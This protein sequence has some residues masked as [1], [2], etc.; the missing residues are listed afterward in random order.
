MAKKGIDV[1]KHQGTIDWA[2]L[3]NKIDF[4]MLRAGYGKLETQID[5]RFKNN[6]NGAKKNNIPVGVYWY[7]YA[8]SEAEA[9]K[10]AEACLK[11]IKGKQFEYPI[12]FDIEEAS[13]LILGKSKVTKIVKA[14]CEKVEKAGYWVGIYSSKSALEDYIEEETRKRYSVWVAHVNVKKTTYSGAY[15]MWQ[16]SW[17]GSFDGIKGDV[18][19][20][21]CYT[22]F[23]TQIKKKGL[24][25][26]EKAT[27]TVSAT[28]KK[29][30]TATTKTATATA[31]K[32]TAGAKITLKDA[33][34]YVSATVANPSATKSGVYYVYDTTVKNNRIRV[35]T[36]AK[37]AGKQPPS[38]YVTGWVKLNEITT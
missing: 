13:T 3:K 20:D 2:K 12:F 33:G 36:T 7:S 15:A 22:D 17:S 9:V 37:N 27:G 10:E 35:T 32:L 26:F 30:T 23:S 25:G 18:D 24:N 19:M 31:T 38:N 11:I 8:K 28:A 6:Y 16:Y 14:F 4:A 29:T 21:Y 34:L 5:P 1:S